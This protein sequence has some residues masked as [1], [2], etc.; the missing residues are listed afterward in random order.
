MTTNTPTDATPRVAQIIVASTRAAAGIYPDR[1]GP[2]IDAWLVDRGWTVD[3][4]HVVPDGDRVG[5]VLGAAIAA[6]CDLVITTGGTGVSPHDE[7]PEQTLPHLDRLIP[8][9]AEELRRR[10]AASTPLALLSRGYVG[11][12]RGR[13]VVVNLPGSTGGVRDGLAVLDDVLPHLIDQ[14]RGR[15]H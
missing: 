12:A 6:H 3:A 7:T 13:T 4:L 11:V 9:L 8:G 10:G 2:V 14:L 15:D 1:T 5:Q